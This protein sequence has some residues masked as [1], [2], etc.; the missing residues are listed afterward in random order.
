[1]PRTNP[2]Q[3]LTLTRLDQIVDLVMKGEKYLT[4][5]EKP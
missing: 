3:H 1:M 5:K 2:S 4:K